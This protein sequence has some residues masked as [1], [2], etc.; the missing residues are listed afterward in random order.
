MTPLKSH[1]PMPFTRVE[2]CVFALVGAELAVLLV[3]RAEAPAKGQ[4]ALPGGVL[5][6][7]LDAALEAAAQRIATERLGTLLPDLRLQTAVGGRS[8]DPRAPWTLSVGFR[9]SVRADALAATPGKR[10]EALMWAPVDEAASGR[11]IAF[12]HSEIIAAA[13]KDLRSEVAA[14]ELPWGLLPTEFTLGELQQ[15]C[16]RVLERPLDK[17]SFRRRLDERRCVEPI[18]GL[19]R[20]AAHRPAQVY[21]PRTVSDRSVD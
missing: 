6:I 9:A 20:G 10:V 17:S 18:H 11:A 8:R 15:D 12:D 1:Y 2:L 16:E 14:L 7:D 19:L 5:R 3:R 4:W 21:R 13:V